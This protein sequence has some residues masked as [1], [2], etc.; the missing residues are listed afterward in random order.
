[1]TETATAAPTPP[2]TAPEVVSEPNPLA[3]MTPAERAAWRRDDTSFDYGTKT[4]TD[5]K[6]AESSPAPPA[7]QAASTD[8]LP[9]AAS[10]PATPPKKNAET[11]IQELLAERHALQARLDALEAARQ[12]PAQTPKAESSP[13]P[14]KSPEFPDYVTWESHNSGQPYEAY[15]DARADFRE[16]Q[17]AQQRQQEETAAAAQREAQ[18]AA[19]AYHGRLQTFTQEHPDFDQVIA[20]L[21]VIPGSPTVNALFEAIQASENG[22]ALAYR[23]GS[24]PAVRTRLIGLPPRLAVYELGKLDA[25]LS[26]A[27]STPAP[28][29][30]VKHTTSA[31]PPPRLVSQR[32]AEPADPVRS[33]IEAGDYRAFKAAEDA[34][35]RARK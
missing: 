32:P 7:E 21:A 33:A 29:V 25:S 4:S 34:K 12:S 5:D 23:L 26:V 13:A 3:A 1:M 19:T 35:D 24:D 14:S 31:P 8:A 20:P 30:P 6:P 15:L 27:A 17:R 9:P 10:E 18:E 11:R 28:P 2:P 16:A 22:P